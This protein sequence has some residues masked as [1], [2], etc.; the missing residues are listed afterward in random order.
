MLNNIFLKKI[1]NKYFLV[2]I[3]MLFLYLTTLQMPFLEAIKW[4][5]ATDV[6]SYLVISNSAPSLPLDKILFHFAQ[7]WIP[8]YLTGIFAGTLHIDLAL[9]YQLLNGIIIFTILILFKS[10]IL[11]IVRFRSMGIFIFLLL[12]LSVYSFRLY[13]FVPGLYADLF[14]VCGLAFAIKGCMDKRYRYVI[15]GMLLATSGK[16]F[17]LMALPGIIL[18]FFSVWSKTEKI[19]KVLFLLSGLILITTFFYILLG[20]IAQRFSVSDQVEFNVFFS[21]FPWLSSDKFTFSLLAEHIL[22]ILIP[23]CPF[24]LMIFIWPSSFKNKLLVLKANESIALIMIA[25]GPIAYAFLPGPE[26][27]M[28]NQGRY[29]GLVLLPVS[30]ITAKIFSETKLHLSIFDFICILFI[31]LNLT[32]HHRYSIIQSSPIS[33]FLTQMIGLL[34]FIIWSISRKKFF[35][36]N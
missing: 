3:T 7:R 28:G 27:Q 30:L 31:L 6:Y 18:Y 34:T 29:V 10:L 25:L 5:Q 9:A 15:F 35:L 19:N 24:L 11:K 17:S 23:L 22:R 21:F 14:F 1:L 12:A 2:F 8:H 16:Q 20:F 4:V 13:I 32:Y 26:L 36:I 33:F